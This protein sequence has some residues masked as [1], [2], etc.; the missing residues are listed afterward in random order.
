LRLNI[1]IRVWLVGFIRGLE[2]AKKQKDLSITSK[3]KF[4]GAKQAR[5]LEDRPVEYCTHLYLGVYIGVF[6]P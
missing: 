6:V 5:D 1:R 4:C 3:G 2:T